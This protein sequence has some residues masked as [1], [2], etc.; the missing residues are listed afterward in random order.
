VTNKAIL[1]KM[2]MP[3]EMFP[4]SAVLVAA[5]DAFP[6]LLILLVGSIAVGWSPDPAG[7]AAAVLGLSIIAVLG[8]ALALLFSSMNVFFRDFQNIVST[9]TIFT[10]WIVPMIYPFSK[11]ATSGIAGTWVYKIYLANP[12]TIA[13]LLMQRAFWVGTLPTCS[14]G[15]KPRSCLEQGNPNSIGF[16]DLP[17]HLY[18]RGVVMLVS[19]FVVL[20][21]CQ[22][23]FRRLEAK[24][25][26]RL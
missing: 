23:V 5:V 24:F 19:S 13:V 21:L 15:L 4:V 14:P 6:Q 9:F 22:L 11:L 7:I 8:I 10:H 1:R 20:G 12:L 26:E 17:D 18:M 2:A 16:P 3:R 25:A